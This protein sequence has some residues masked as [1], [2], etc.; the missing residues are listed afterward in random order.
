[1]DINSFRE[2]MRIKYGRRFKDYIS[3][4]TERLVKSGEKIKKNLRTAGDVA[5]Y[6][7][8]LKKSFINAAGGIDY[9]VECV[10]PQVIGVIDRPDFTVEK[11]VFQSVPCNYVTCNLYKPKL[12]KKNA[13]L[14]A[15]IFVCGHYPEAKTHP[16]YQS[17]MQELMRAGFA[18]LG[19]DPQGQGERL[20]YYNKET[21][22]A[23]IDGC[24]VEHSYN[25]AKAWLT[26]KPLNHYFIR[27]IQCAIDYLT[28]R[29][30]IDA[31]KIGLTGN[32]GGGTQT[33]L[34]ML[35]QDERIKAFAPA[36]Y[37]T[38]FIELFDTWQA[39]DDEQVFTGMLKNGFD[40]DDIIISVAPRPVML[41][42]VFHDFFP[43]GGTI[44]TFQSARE[45]YEALGC[46]ENLELAIDNF[47]HKYTKP[48]AKSAARF[49][50]KHLL[51]INNYEGSDKPYDILE[52]KELW[53][54][55]SGQVAGDFMNARFV[56]D[57]IKDLGDAQFN[58]VKENTHAKA[59]AVKFLKEKVFF[60]RDS[61]P[62]LRAPLE[63]GIKESG[64]KPAGGFRFGK[65]N[66][67]AF[68][69]GS[70][71]GLKNLA[72][73]YSLKGNCVKKIKICFFDYGNETVLENIKFLDGNV[74]KDTAVIAVDISNYGFLKT[75]H[76][77]IYGFP[78]YGIYGFMYQMSHQ[79]F[80]RGDSIA[81]LKIF[82][83][84]SA[85]RNIRKHFAGCEA[86]IYAEGRIEVLTAAALLINGE[87][88]KYEFAGR[89][90][91]FKAIIDNRYDYGDIKSYIIPSFTKYCDY[92]DLLKWL[93]E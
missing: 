62:A 56:S 66:A 85:I 13:R 49:F 32:S 7:K 15:V 6:Q 68:T 70:V 77:D 80:F 30:D 1:M 25:G 41:L 23:D 76:K 72:A 2:K 31:D 69:F 93:A 60:G 11:I 88:T 82:E 29:E 24:T 3:K 19:V 28:R 74:D 34:I 54:T 5:A 57:E 59:E 91:G 8:T 12:P 20:N 16:E 75:E 73:V 27:D 64:L 18:V 39:V 65:Y 79:M 4:D 81:A 92:G 43:I 86:E 35:S 84:L 44:K 17:V 45:V 36:T 26:G 48:L 53:I 52:G 42:A 61:R 87:K 63:R 71:G 33:S 51:G 78:L 89:F 46:K 38:G 55:K 14:P 10:N 9:N 40:H 22:K 50:A 90:E 67:E 47:N 21:K 83:I 37:I 58:A